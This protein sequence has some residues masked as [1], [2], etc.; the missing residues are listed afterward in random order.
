M[1]T[2]S[3]LW[4]SKNKHNHHVVC[5]NNFLLVIFY[6]WFLWLIFNHT[7]ELWVFAL[8]NHRQL[9]QVCWL[10]A[11]FQSSAR[12]S[13]QSLSSFTYQTAY[14]KIIEEVPNTNNIYVFTFTYNTYKREISLHC[15]IDSLTHSSLERQYIE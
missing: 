13:S 14:C 12:E 2:P 15:I 10:M 3:I 8:Q 5:K 7:T 4:S 9:P 1:V 11:L 6:Y